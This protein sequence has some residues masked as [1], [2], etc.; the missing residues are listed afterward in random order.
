[1]VAMQEFPLDAEQA[2]R[3]RVLHFVPKVG[4]WQ[5]PS[6]MTSHL[7]F[8]NQQSF[9]LIRFLLDTLR[10]QGAITFAG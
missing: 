8:Y 3:I 6:F 2:L 7:G 9:N 1:M 5:A 10:F 4:T